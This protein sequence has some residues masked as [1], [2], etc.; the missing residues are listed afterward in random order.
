M[1]TMRRLKT[2]YVGVYYIMGTA[3]GTGKPERIYYV[4]YRRDG[5]LIE[6][7]AGRQFSDAMTPAKASRMRAERIEGKSLSNKARR[8]ETKRR[9]FGN[10]QLS[11]YGKNT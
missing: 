10:G 7:K 1:P 9:R 3:I 8:E 6:E 4:L 11:D 2:D 5:K